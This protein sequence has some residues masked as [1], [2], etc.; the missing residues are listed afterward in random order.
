MLK[1]ITFHP[2][3][4][5]GQLD[6]TLRDLAMVNIL[7]GANGAGKSRV[8]RA[9]Q[10]ASH[11]ISY[12]TNNSVTTEPLNILVGVKIMLHAA[13]KPL[14]IKSQEKFFRDAMRELSTGELT[15][16]SITYQKPSPLGTPL[17]VIEEEVRELRFHGNP[18][19]RGDSAIEMQDLF[20]GGTV[21]LGTSKK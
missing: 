1:S 16:H 5:T 7:V 14:D 6:L 15:E 3:A 12:R 17:G 11:E 9:I 21:R 13:N 2:V 4:E 18:I 8:L 19:V 10:L 20:S